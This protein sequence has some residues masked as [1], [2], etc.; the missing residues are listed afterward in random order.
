MVNTKIGSSFMAFFQKD[1]NQRDEQK[2]ESRYIPSQ[3]ESESSNSSFRNTS[4][5]MDTINTIISKG[6]QISGNIVGNDS[7]QID[8]KV[9]G[10]IRAKLLVI[11]QQGVVEGH[12]EAETVI[13]QGIISGGVSCKH[14]E[15]SHLGKI[16]DK[17]QVKTMLLNGEVFGEIFAETSIVVGDKGQVNAKKI[18]SKKIMVN[19]S[20]KGVL[21]AS[22]LLEVGRN[23]SVEGEIMVKNI[24]TE[25][26]GKVIG[27]MLAYVEPK[28]VTPLL[29]TEVIESS[30]V[31]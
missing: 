13:V 10:D 25:E 28:I 20:V 9:R 7:I 30:V 11:G 23:G 16:T 26:G 2:V 15:L 1:K 12:I 3:M 17:I 19:G 31:D 14:L 6:I 4:V 5:N 24:K 18:Q 22:E 29:E 8:G 21:C 27:S